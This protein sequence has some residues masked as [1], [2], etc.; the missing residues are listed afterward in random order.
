MTEDEARRVEDRLE[1]RLDRLEEDVTRRHQE[2]VERLDRLEQAM[3]RGA[4]AMAVI[5]A[6]WLII[7]ALLGAAAD[8]FSRRTGN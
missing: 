7:A 6:G 8:Y 5:R 3:A 1:K 2:N 4:G